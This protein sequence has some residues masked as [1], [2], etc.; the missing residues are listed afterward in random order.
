M[1][2][3]IRLNPFVTALL[4]GLLAVAVG[5]TAETAPEKDKKDKK[6]EE[7]IAP[8]RAA[9][10]KNPVQPDAKSL[11]QGRKLYIRECLSC[12]GSVGKGDGP[13]AKELERSP[14]DLSD[15]AKM[16]KQT[17]GALFWKI[18]EGKKPMLSTA[19]A[20]TEEER[21]KV[22]N[23]IRTFVPAKPKTEDG[24]EKPAE[25]EKKSP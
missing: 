11:S 25:S 20:L 6:E 14:G 18:T 12:H 4:L 16:N 1:K 3:Q 17:D 23:Y 9:K 8:E 19:T 22:V 21:W 15:A 24:K 10:K 7:W 5:L 2:T 13:K